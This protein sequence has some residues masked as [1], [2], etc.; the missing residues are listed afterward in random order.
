M[1]TNSKLI[2]NIR[3]LF[4]LTLLAAFLLTMQSCKKSRSD[5]GKTLFTKTKNKVFKDV[6]PE[7]FAAVFEKVLAE[8]KDS[9]NNSAIITGYY[10]SHDYDPVLLMEHLP[11]DDVKNVVNW[12]QRSGEHG[13]DPKTFYTAQI[14]AELNKFYAKKGIKTLDEA[15]HDMAN[16]ELLLAN[17]LISYS[18]AMQY[19]ILS[20]RKIYARYFTETKRP[21]TAAMSRIFGITDMK[22]YMDSIQPKNPQYIALQKALA[23]DIPR[24][25]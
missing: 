13:L 20:P 10:Q 4:I 5:M 8:H 21:D 16:L 9:L 24:R 15:Y 25:V 3:P 22:A 11:N 18:N 17:S 12:Y 19:G 14:Q 23:G 7:G 2:K 1:L 6:T